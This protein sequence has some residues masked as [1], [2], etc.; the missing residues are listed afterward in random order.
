M[1][2]RYESGEV[3][4]STTLC[5]IRGLPGMMER[6]EKE[7]A[8]L[9]V[10]TIVP[11]E[12][13]GELSRGDIGEIRGGRDVLDAMVDVDVDGRIRDA[14]T[15]RLMKRLDWDVKSGPLN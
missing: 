1:G 15:G 13:I 8:G 7:R 5:E 3:A 2:V 10:G 11:L 14:F 9:R 6:V 4:G 12:D